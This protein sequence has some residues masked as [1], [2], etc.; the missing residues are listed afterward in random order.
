MTTSDIILMTSVS[1]QLLAIL[2][3]ATS[4]WSLGQRVSA[5]ID[6]LDKD[7][8]ANTVALERLTSRMDDHTRHHT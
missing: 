4:V 3:L 1:V 6:G 7:V 5:R 2:A 8:A